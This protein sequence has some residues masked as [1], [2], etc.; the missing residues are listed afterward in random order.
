M[1]DESIK[2]KYFKTYANCIPVKG[3]SRSLICDVQRGSYDFIT[4]DLY[5]ILLDQSN[6]P[7][8]DI[9]SFYGDENEEVLLEYFDFLHSREY[10]FFCDPHELDLFPDLDLSWH[11]PSLVT[12]AIIDVGINFQHNFVKL[13]KEI[14][15]LGCKAIQIRFFRPTELIEVAD[16]LKLLEKTSIIS[17]ELFL[18]FI[19]NLNNTELYQL[20]LSNLRINMLVFHSAPTENYFD[21][22]EEFNAKV[23]V[24]SQKINDESHCGVI[25]KEYFTINIESFTESLNYNSCLNRKISIDQYGYIK[26]C[27]SLNITYGHTE[28]DSLSSVIDSVQFTSYWKI[29]KDQIE[30]CKDCEFRYICTDCRAYTSNN[31]LYSKPAKCGYNPYTETWD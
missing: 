2:D 29:N 8:K 28:N 6:A 19:F 17:I 9:L 27:P 5:D 11:S 1:F 18:P 25:S 12:N 23:I 26:N 15:A 3:A 31:N 13:F 30:I 14:E 21:V 7:I 20:V 22:K 10:I 16:I 24:T 4:N